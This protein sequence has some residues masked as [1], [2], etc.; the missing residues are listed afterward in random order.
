MQLIMRPVSKFEKEIYA[1]V[2]LSCYFD[3]FKHSKNILI[4]CNVPIYQIKIMAAVVQNSI[5]GIYIL[6][7]HED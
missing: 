2:A 7:Q 6:Q 1:E 3:N 4:P 5:Q